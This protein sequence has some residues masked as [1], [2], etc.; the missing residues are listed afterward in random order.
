MLSTAADA[1][2]V[3]Q[4]APWLAV[5]VLALVAAAW[6]FRQ[7]R[8]SLQ[9][10]EDRLSLSAVRQGKRLGELTQQ[11]GLLDL[12]RR[13][14]EW[15]LVDEGL[16]LPY[17]PAD[18]PDQPRPRPRPRRDVDEDQADELTEHGTT[19]RPRIPVPPLDPEVAARHRRDRT[20]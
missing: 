6:V 9:A 15:V 4:A 5:G 14:V 1:L 7:G 19:E 16:E 12:R 2:A 20:A 13:Q 18:G 3:A 11:V 17:W 8:R 10:A